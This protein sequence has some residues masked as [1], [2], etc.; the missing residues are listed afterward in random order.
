MDV[1]FPTLDQSAWRIS[2]VWE[3]G[4]RW[5]YDLGNPLADMLRAGRRMIALFGVA[6]GALV[7]Y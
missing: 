3:M 4:F 1:K 6:T 7:F 2:D 5:F